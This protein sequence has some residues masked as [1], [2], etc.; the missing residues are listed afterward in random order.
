MP[1]VVV[2]IEVD[3]RFVES[4]DFVPSLLKLLESIPGIDDVFLEK[5]S[6]KKTEVDNS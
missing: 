1:S 4:E 5:V 2:K 6:E 3:K